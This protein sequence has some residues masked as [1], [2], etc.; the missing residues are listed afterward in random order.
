MKRI[1]IYI[2]LLAASILLPSRGMD[3]GKLK[4]VGLVQLYKEGGTVFILTD[5]GD[6]GE[7]ET[8]EAAFENLEKTTS[9]V[10]F[11]D[12]ADY[13]LIS[14]SAMYEIETI[15]QYLKPAIDVC[16][17]NQ[18]IDLVKAA[19]YLAVHHPRVELKDKNVLKAAQTLVMENNRLILK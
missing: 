13:L 16:V 15:K 12:T 2:A 18:G 9:G 4:P 17:A 3:V 10:I 6:S 19:E 5:T 8:V 1:A 14:K 7:G 11:L